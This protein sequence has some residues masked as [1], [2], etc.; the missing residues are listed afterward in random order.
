[1][2]T[3]EKI[4]KTYGLS[5]KNFKILKRLN[6]PKKIQDFLDTLPLNWEHGHETYM[7]VERTMN[8]GKAHCLEAALLA[9]LALWIQG[10]PPLLLD[11]KSN[12]GDDHIIALYKIGKNKSTQAVGTQR[13]GAISKTNHTTLRFRDPI[14]MSVRELAVSYFHEYIHLKTGEKI[15]ESYS[16]PFDLRKLDKRQIKDWVSGVEDLFWLAEAI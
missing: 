4:C 5:P 16:E 15:L 7:S 2:I 1:M 10:E 9:S 11:L 12:N 13:W 8:A 14:Y 6:S 3:Q